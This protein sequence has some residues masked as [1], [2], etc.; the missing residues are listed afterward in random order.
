MPPIDWLPWVAIA[1]VATAIF[2]GGAL[3]IS[4]KRYREARVDTG[5]TKP[6]VVRSA[7]PHAPRFVSDE[8]EKALNIRE[9]NW[10]KVR[11]L[12]LYVYNRS[13]IP[14]PLTF[15]RLRILWP[16]KQHHYL[17]GTSVYQ[18]EIP[19]HGGGNIPVLVSNYDWLNLENPD[20]E[21][22]FLES[23]HSRALVW[24]RGQTLSGHK[25]SHVGW[26]KF[27]LISHGSYFGV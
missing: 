23:E 20:E 4:W 6:L 7:R 5:R 17:F 8:I 25:I 26:S 1:T 10:Y 18:Y 21:A 16:F 27:G 15:T 12:E 19:A 11:A 22:V 3:V 13:T 24:I 14:Q 9:E 2:T